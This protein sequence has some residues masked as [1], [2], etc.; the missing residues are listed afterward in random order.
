MEWQELLG[1]IAGAIVALSLLMRS[2]L[3]LRIINLAG[4]VGF[5]VYG[6]M[7]GS[8]P[9]FVLNLIIALADAYYIM[10]F[11]T[12]R[13][14]FSIVPERAGTPHFAYL[15]DLYR[16]DIARQFPGHELSVP[17]DAQAFIVLRDSV[18]VGLFIYAV[19]GSEARVLLDY[20]IPRYRDMRPGRYL[21]AV[22]R[23]E[24]AARGIRRIVAPGWGKNH[25]RYQKIMGFVRRGEDWVMEMPEEV[26][27]HGRK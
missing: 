25:R 12:R 16:N 5:S 10:L 17:A 27:K 14:Y 21:Y 1:Y 8:V 6:L 7:I 11:L 2:A 19:K 18:A 9:V 20:V 26:R 4:A 13:E 22:L 23:D 24:F 15:V 3:K